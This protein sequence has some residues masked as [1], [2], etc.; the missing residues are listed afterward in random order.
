MACPHAPAAE[1]K[2]TIQTILLIVQPSIPAN[3]RKDN[4]D[5]S[6]RTLTS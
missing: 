5:Q 1:I 6:G 2:H 3:Q 4:P